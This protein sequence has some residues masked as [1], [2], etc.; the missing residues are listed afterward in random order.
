[1][2]CCG[3][4][5]L[6]DCIVVGRWRPRSFR[7]RLGHCCMEKALCDVCVHHPR[8]HNNPKGQDVNAQVFILIVG[9]SCCFIC[10]PPKARAFLIMPIPTV[11]TNRVLIQQ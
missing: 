7:Q 8:H 1:M 4:L 2:S 11:Q 3:K 5:V 10:R 9:G 6:A